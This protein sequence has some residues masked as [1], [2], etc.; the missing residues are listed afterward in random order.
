MGDRPWKMRYTVTVWFM[1]ETDWL[2]A[3]ARVGMAGK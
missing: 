3:R 1:V 2:N